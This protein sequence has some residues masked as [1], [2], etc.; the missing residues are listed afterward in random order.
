VKLLNEQ[1]DHFSLVMQHL[2]YICSKLLAQPNE[3]CKNNLVK[4]HDVLSIWCKCKRC[5]SSYN[6]ESI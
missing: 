1:L 6:P 2:A 4:L 5:H 3:K